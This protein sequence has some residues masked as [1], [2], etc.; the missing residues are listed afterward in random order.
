M[1]SV[2]VF[3]WASFLF[4][5]VNHITIGTWYR[6]KYC[7][8]FLVLW[9]HTFLLHIPYFFPHSLYLSFVYS[10]FI[11]DWCCWLN[12]RRMPKKREKKQHN[13]HNDMREWVHFIAFVQTTIFPIHSTFYLLRFIHLSHVTNLTLF[14]CCRLLALFQSNSHSSIWF[15]DDIFFFHHYLLLLLMFLSF[16]FHFHQYTN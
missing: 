1:D 9:K 12:K 15:L 11:C 3:A 4:L 16:L 8:I 14:F 6:R 7:K 10:L 2:E 5:H 13:L